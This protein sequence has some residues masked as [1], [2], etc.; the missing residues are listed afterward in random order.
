MHPLPSRIDESLDLVLA[1][2][3]LDLPQCILTGATCHG[4]KAAF[5]H[6]NGAV[7]ESGECFPR[8]D[9]KGG[10]WWHIL[11]EGTQKGRLA[12]LRNLQGAFGS[13]AVN[14]AQQGAGGAVARW[15]EEL[16]AFDFQFGASG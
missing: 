5:C 12:L 4:V 13:G 9:P 8:R 14:Q 11:Q 16:K 6:R 10:E 7:W 2:S 3:T 15:L 1:F